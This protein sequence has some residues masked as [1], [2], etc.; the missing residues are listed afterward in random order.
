MGDRATYH[1]SSNRLSDA[2]SAQELFVEPRAP[3]IGGVVVPADLSTVFQPIV[4]LDA[5]EVLAYEALVRC[6]AHGLSPTNL[7]ERAAADKSA[8]RLGRMVR[9]IAVRFAAVPPSS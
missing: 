9:E 7:F 5:G 8:G 6:A 3:F 4:A 1:P 2:P